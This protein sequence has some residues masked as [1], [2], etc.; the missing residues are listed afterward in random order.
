MENSRKYV[1]L[2]AF[3]N[4]KVTFIA[5]TVIML[6]ILK[7]VTNTELLVGNMGLSYAII[8][9]ILNGLTALLTGSL[10]AIQVWK[11]DVFTLKASIGGSIGSILGVLTGG[12]AVCGFTLASYLGLAG[13]LTTLPFMGLELKILG[14]LLLAW[15][16]WNALSI[17]CRRR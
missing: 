10:V 4:C 1:L 7:V 5:V 3:R 13:I 2:Q 8:V 9:W 15:A 14:V 6:V 12:C 11:W 17:I 16:N